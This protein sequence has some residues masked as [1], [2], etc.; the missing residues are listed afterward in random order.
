MLGFFFK[1]EQQI[2]SLLDSYLGNLEMSKESFLKCMNC[3]F[4]KH[5][6]EEFHFLTEQTHKYESNADDIRNEIETMMYAKVLLPESRGDILGLLEAID[7]IPNLFEHV[8]YMI[9]TQ[10]LK[11]PDSITSDIQEL[12]RASLEC[13]DL[14]IRQ[15]RALFEKTEDMKPLVLVID[16]NESY[17]DHIER[18]IITKVFDSD[19]DPF[20]KLQV[21]E[22][23]LQMGEISD[24]ADRVSRRV[25]IISIKRRV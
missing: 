21:K 24:Q 25:H 7:Q 8:L 3:Y 2:E 13:C 20:L 5:L 11:I 17:C 15:V 1:E 14:L 18:R 6:H 12:L 16:Q 9:Q 22:M 23:V 19:L 4:E 10:K